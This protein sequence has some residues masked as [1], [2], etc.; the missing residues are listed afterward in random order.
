MG[1]TAGSALLRSLQ[2]Q[3]EGLSQK[4]NQ[5]LGSCA[6][7]RR[8]PALPAGQPPGQTSKKLS[9][10]AVGTS[11]LAGQGALLEQSGSVRA[12]GLTSV[13][14]RARYDEDHR[15]REYE[16]VCLQFAR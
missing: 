11:R 14:A 9:G 16:M 4:S 8:A 1:Q 2:L 6:Q 10:L 15:P 3:D 7:W 5:A 12:E 13:E